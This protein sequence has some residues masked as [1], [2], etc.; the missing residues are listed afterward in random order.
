MPQGLSPAST[1]NRELSL[2]SKVAVC[3]FGDDQWQKGRETGGGAPTV[4]AYAVGDEMSHRKG[5]GICARPVALLGFMFLPGRSP[6]SQVSPVRTGQ[7]SEP[8]LE[9][10]G[11][12]LLSVGR[13]TATHKNRDKSLTSYYHKQGTA[14]L[15]E[16]R[17][18]KGNN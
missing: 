12:V 18:H 15:R 9:T 2:F 17:T 10:T 5:Q 14:E 16:I 8:T 7:R 13:Y 1:P 3:Q 6:R 11:A 4:T